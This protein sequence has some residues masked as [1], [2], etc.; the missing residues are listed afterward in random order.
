MCN[1]PKKSGTLRTFALRNDRILTDIPIGVA[2]LSVKNTIEKVEIH[3]WEKEKDQG[4]RM[5]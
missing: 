5:R 3:K 4:K 1:C 2:E